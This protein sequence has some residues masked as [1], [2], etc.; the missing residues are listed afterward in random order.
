MPKAKVTRSVQTR[1]KPDSVEAYLTTLPPDS[2]VVVRKIMALVKNSVPGCSD[3]IS[4]GIL[5]FSKG[6]IF[7]YCAAFKSHIGIYPPVRGDAKLIRELRP[8][9]N[10]KGNLRFPLSQPVPYP[11]L[12]RVAKALAK[13]YSEKPPSRARS[14]AGAKS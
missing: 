2:A 8:Y 1:A 12:A 5:A 4:Y 11:T 6:R 7:M 9:A 10:E 3:S 14:K 13:A